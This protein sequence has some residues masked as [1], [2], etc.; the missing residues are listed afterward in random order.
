MK[1]NLFRLGCLTVL[2]LV[3]TGSI[4]GKDKDNKPDPFAKVDKQK[5]ESAIKN[6]LAFLL[7]SLKENQELKPRLQSIYPELK[8]GEELILYTLIKGGAD[9]KEETFNALFEK[10]LNKKL[11]RTYRVSLL[12]MALSELDRKKYQAKIAECG[13]FLIDNQCENG[14][15]DY[16]KPVEP[17]NIK[18]TP[19]ASDS[20]KEKEGSTDAMRRVPLG[21]RRKG[22]KTGDNSNTQYACLGLRACMQAGIIIPDTIFALT[23]QWLEK[24]QQKDGSWGYGSPGHGQ[25]NPGYGS[26]TIGALGSLIICKFY[27]T[28]RI[29][30]NDP[31]I[32][33]GIDW[34]VKNFTV[35]ENPKISPPLE[36]YF[37]HYYYLYAME[38]LGAFLETEDFGKYEWYPTGA[39]LLLGNQ[40]KSGSWH[41][42]FD[43]TCFAILFLRRATKPLKAVET[44]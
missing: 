22:P 20:P 38:R 32:L 1:N 8:S 9:T 31:K 3:L 28:K 21:Q 36:G 42:V 30:K 13:Q 19:S 12:A 33:Q 11:E 29:P 37:G 16:G 44:K 34:L 4:F 24:N 5:V 17:L 40:D 2:L 15:W 25:I 39:E 35:K 43:D 6:G 27:L 26:M 7:N 41:N 10:T 14:Q 23:Q 18:I